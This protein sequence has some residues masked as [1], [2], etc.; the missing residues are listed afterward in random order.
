MMI[1]RISA[2]KD[3]LSRNIPIG[4][5]RSPRFSIVLTTLFLILRKRNDE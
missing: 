5:L 3:I 2:D 1:Y 4:V